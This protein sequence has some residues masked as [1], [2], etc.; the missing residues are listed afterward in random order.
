MTQMRNVGRAFADPAKHFWSLVNRAGP[1]ECWE[2]TRSR[3][4]SGY[5]RY[6]VRG[7]RVVASR[8][9]YET[10]VGAIPPGMVVCHR[11]D[12]P[13]CCNPSHL[14]IGTHLENALDKIR[15]GRANAVRGEANPAAKL[16]AETVAR[17]KQLR[18]DGLKYRELAERF[19]VPM[20]TIGHIVTNRIWVHVG[21]NNLPAE[22]A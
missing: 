17:I 11:C 4:S 3:T 2:W 5:G 21:A 6:K 14:F 18:A 13:G 15:K 20:S 1:D 16:N 8:F 12:N 7:K 19:D 10:T 9:A 22:A